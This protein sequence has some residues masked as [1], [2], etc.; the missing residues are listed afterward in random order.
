M[1]ALKWGLKATLCNLPTIV[2]NCALLWPFWA[3]FQGESSSQNDDNRRQSWT[4]VD[5]CLK[6][7]FRLSRMKTCE[8]RSKVHH[9]TNACDP[10]VLI[11]RIAAI[12]EGDRRTLIS[13][14][15]KEGLL[16]S[17]HIERERCGK[18]PLSPG[19]LWGLMGPSKSAPRHESRGIPLPVWRCWWEQFFPRQNGPQ[20]FRHRAI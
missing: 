14:V 10:K 18:I 3:P 20:A 6:P 8:A 15:I 5:K 16:G 2:H 4:I 12:E 1:G 7:P 17:R 19:N 9:Y 11:S 13:P